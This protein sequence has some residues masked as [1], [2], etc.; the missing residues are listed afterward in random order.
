[1]SL[2]INTNPQLIVEALKEAKKKG[3]IVLA[4][5]SNEGAN[6]AISFPARLDTVFCIGSADGKGFRS[7][8]SPPFLGEEKYSALGE[9]VSGALPVNGDSKNRYG[10][11]T[12]TSTAV[13][14]AAGISALLMDFTRQFMETWSGDNNWDNIRKIFLTMS[15]ATAGESYRYLS[16]RYLF[17]LSN[18]TKSLIKSVLRKPAGMF[19]CGCNKTYFS[20]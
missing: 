7:N 10:R 5:A 9:A 17:T 14:V 16:P 6:H 12:G 4:S 8:F 13:A 18:D 1:M 19:V 3:I 2:G 11:R 15:E 20:A